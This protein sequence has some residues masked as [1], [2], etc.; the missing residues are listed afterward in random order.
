MLRQLALVLCVVPA[1]WAGS[2]ADAFDNHCSSCHG[3][4]AAGTNRA[5]SLIR[6][7][8][9]HTDAEVADLIRTGRIEKGMP[10]FALRLDAPKTTHS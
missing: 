2:G 8:G 1:A 4:D 9:Y 5:P 6:F 3:G 7:I 10:A